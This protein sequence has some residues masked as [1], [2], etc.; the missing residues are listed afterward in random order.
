MAHPRLGFNSYILPK[1]FRG[2]RTYDSYEP[3][4][5]GKHP[6]DVWPLQPIMPSA[7]E[8]L[9]YPTQK[10]ERLLEYILRASSNEGNL[11]LDPFCGCGTAVAVAQR[12]N[13]R[14]IGIDITHLAI[15]LIKHRLLTAFGDKVSFKTIGEPV[16]LPDALALAS[17]DRYQFQWWAL[18]MVGARPTEKK[19]GADA[20]ID[21]R[22]LFHDEPSGGRTKQIIF[23]VKSGGVDVGD[24]RDL[25]GVLDQQKAEIGVLLTLQEPTGPMRKAAASAGFYSSPWG[26][27]HPRLQIRTIAELLEGRAVDR[28]AAAVPGVNV[29]LKDARPAKAAGSS[30]QEDLF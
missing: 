30:E 19:K 20:G 11:I 9:G 15:S 28:P 4:P 6:D 10:P 24:V 26:T 5:L 23:S 1:S 2:E 18:G 7:K 27:K 14:W 22:L 16:T 13:R 29:T 8:R 3:N 17:Q 12:L 21:G 25:L